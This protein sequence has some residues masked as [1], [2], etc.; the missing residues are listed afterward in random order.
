MYMGMND[1]KMFRSQ[2]NYIDL[3]VTCISDI[4][5]QIMHAILEIKGC[6]ID[7]D[8]FFCGGRF[9]FVLFYLRWTNY[10]A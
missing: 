9:F 10:A 5:L 1:D 4:P 3:T 8:T 2:M 6:L 7:I